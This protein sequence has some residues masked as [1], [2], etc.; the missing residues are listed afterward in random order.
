MDFQRIL[1][2]AILALGY[3]SCPE[4]CEC[5]N[6]GKLVKCQELTEMP[7]FPST[8]EIWKPYMKKMNLCI[9]NVL[10]LKKLIRRLLI[11]TLLTS[12]LGTK[13]LSF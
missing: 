6:T 1:F 3:S 9:E 5:S 11:G 2:L 7:D 10:L 12:S 8:E 13:R 4:S